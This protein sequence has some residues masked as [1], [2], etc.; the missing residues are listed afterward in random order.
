M[1][2]KYNLKVQ[3]SEYIKGKKVE[4]FIKA[5]PVQARKAVAGEKIVT[6]V[7]DKNT[8]KLIEETTVTATEN[9]WVI[10]NKGGEIYTN[11]DENFHK[12]Y[13]DS[14]KEGERLPIS[15]PR[16]CVKVTENISFTAPWGEKMYIQAGGM[17]NVDD[18]DNIYG[19]NPEEFK[20]THIPFSKDMTK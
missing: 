2:K 16:K 15:K 1:G 14:N 6:Y 3:D 13:G 19:I 4:L 12:L 11:S 7:K 20:E 17:L 18:E 10:K 8:G 9:M 5:T